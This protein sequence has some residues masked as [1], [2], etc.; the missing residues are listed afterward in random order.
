M[1]SILTR[2]EYCGD[3][4]NFKTATHYRDKHSVYVDRSQ[5]QIFENVHEPIIDRETFENVQRILKNA[6]VKRP[7][8]DGNIHPLSGLMYCK[9]CGTK[10]H[11][12]TIHKNGK[13]QHVTYCSEYAKGKAK[14][15]KC[16]SP[17]RIDVDCVMQ[18]IAEVLRKI[19]QFALANKA[20]FEAMVKNSLAQ[21]QT[22]ETKKQQ[23]RMPQIRH[24]I[25]QIEM[26]MNK[27]Y[28]D[29]AIGKIEQ[30]R[31][32]QLS[33][34]YSDEYYTLKKELEEIEERLSKCENAN[35]R[36]KRF[37][38]LVERYCD[39]EELTPTAINE[40]ISRI[41][42]HERDVKRAKFA[43]QRVEVYFN[44]IGKFENELTEQLEP[45]EEQCKRMM[46]EIEEGRREKSRAYH[47][48]YSKNYRAKNIEKRREYERMK[49]REYRAKK[50]L[51]A[52]T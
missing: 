24:R 2:Q 49:A 9:D 12:R 7:N 43:V 30:E 4:V 18:N 19:A 14:H 32:E 23:K 41:V 38:R 47:R 31:Y 40:F 10:M 35:Q 3:V 33:Q 44:Y 6:P 11:I 45:T 27:L 8:G 34:K 48:E 51:Q 42:V 25:E 46:E 50:K 21:E 1:T 5:W 16:N 39:F 36:A 29:N 37:I 20:E 52:A 28:E 26:F 22:D 13:V 15:P 17:H